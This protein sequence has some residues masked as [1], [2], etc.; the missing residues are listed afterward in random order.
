MSHVTAIRVITLMCSVKRE[1]YEWVLLLSY[2]SA[3]MFKFC[4]EK[5]FPNTLNK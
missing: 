4:P 1:N 2:F 5:G 3:L